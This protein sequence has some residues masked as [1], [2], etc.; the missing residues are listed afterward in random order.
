MLYTSRLDGTGMRR[1]AGGDAHSPAWAPRGNRLAWLTGGP[2]E[3]MGLVVARP[4]GTGKRILMRS[5]GY[6]LLLTPI[7]TPDGRRLRAPVIMWSPLTEGCPASGR[8]VE[9]DPSSGRRRTLGRIP[10]LYNP[11]G[12]RAVPREGRWSQ[13]GSLLAIGGER[14]CEQQRL[15]IGGSGAGVLASERSHPSH[16][17]PG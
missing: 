16:R 9:V 6:N 4:D 8:L 5:T 13:D 11:H 12:C 14:G 3:D 17:P 7:W 10:L 15:R 2:Y 1:V